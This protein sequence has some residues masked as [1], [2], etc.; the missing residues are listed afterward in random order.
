MDGRERGMLHGA[1][2]CKVSTDVLF[3]DKFPI[4]SCA[5]SLRLLTNKYKGPLI[6][7]TNGINE[8]DIYTTY[9]KITGY[10]YL[11]WNYINTIYPTGIISVVKWYDQSGNGY[12]LTATTN[13]RLR[14]S[15]AGITTLGDNRN[16]FYNLN[17]FIGIAGLQISPA[18]RMINSSINLTAPITYLTVQSI[19][20]NRT[21]GVIFDSYN[22]SQCALYNTGTLETPNYRYTIANGTNVR[23]GKDIVSAQMNLTTGILGGSS[24]FL[25]VDY[26]YGNNISQSNNNL[27]GLSI[28]NI[29]GNPNPIVANY[30]WI[31]LVFE[32]IIY[33]G[34]LFDK[35]ELMKKQLLK[36]YKIYSVLNFRA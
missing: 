17:G 6:R 9:D 18:P 29:R 25:G 8:T 30:N 36:D 14:N 27:N 13:P 20:G 4:P 5:Y 33:Q 35:I 3:L 15:A 11:D 7:V 2:S 12:D 22:N 16:P 19:G 31:G 28:L 21:A 1:Y 34:N 10:N 32:I 24:A 26:G 23:N